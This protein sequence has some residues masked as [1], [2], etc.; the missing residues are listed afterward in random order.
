[1]EEAIVL[2][3]EA[4]R[5]AHVR[6]L[7][8]PHQRLDRCVAYLDA[9]LMEVTGLQVWHASPASTPCIWPN[10]SGGDLTALCVST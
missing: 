2:L 9:H 1:M 3:C 6:G 4:T 5:S 8:E 7:F 10:C